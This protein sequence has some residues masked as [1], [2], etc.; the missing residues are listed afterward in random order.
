MLG[1]FFTKQKCDRCSGSF[2]T[3]WI[4]SMH[5]DLALCMGYKEAETRRSDYLEAVEVES[6]AVRH[7]VFNFPGIAE[8]KL[9]KENIASRT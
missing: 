7:G 2:A 3:G 6:A 1:Y 9:V 4:Q 5:D 8:T